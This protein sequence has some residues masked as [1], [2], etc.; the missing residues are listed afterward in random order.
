M[1][2]LPQTKIN[3][4]WSGLAFV[5]KYYGSIVALLEGEKLMKII[6]ILPASHEGSPALLPANPQDHSA[7]SSCVYYRRILEWGSGGGLGSSN[8]GRQRK[9]GVGKW[10]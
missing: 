1:F 7:A 6:A 4:V 9:G 8:V 3:S 2:H 10:Q 5:W